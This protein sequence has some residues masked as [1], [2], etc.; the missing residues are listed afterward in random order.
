MG[1]LQYVNKPMCHILCKTEHLQLRELMQLFHIMDSIL[2][3]DPQSF[4]PAFSHYWWLMYI[5][6]PLPYFTDFYVCRSLIVSKSYELVGFSL[7]SV[8]DMI[9]ADSQRALYS[10]M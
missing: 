7:S 4:I 8:K 3:S 5:P 1:V 10:N 6:S 9:M 2:E